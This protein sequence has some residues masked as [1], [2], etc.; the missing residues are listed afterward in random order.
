[1][2]KSKT[3]ILIL[4]VLVL[5]FAAVSF[6]G[7]LGGED[8]PA[9]NETAPPAGNET[10][11]PAGNETTPPAGNVTTPPT[12]KAGSVTVTLGE[13]VPTPILVQVNNQR[14]QTSTVNINVGDTI[15]IRNSEQ[16]P[17]RHLYH[18]ENNAFED[19]RLDHRYRAALTFNEPGTF[20]IHL[21]NPGTG[22]PHNPTNPQI[23]TV[24]VT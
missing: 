7:C 24:I 10:A 1:M 9:G 2:A 4:A 6:S 15:G 16:R 3:I 20:R 5:L 8:Q 22:E 17:F 13:S 11:P 18:S 14:F 23:L 21:L 12:S 19:F